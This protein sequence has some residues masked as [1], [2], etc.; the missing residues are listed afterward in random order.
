MIVRYKQTAKLNTLCPA[1]RCALQ[2]DGNTDWQLTYRQL[3]QRVER[4]AAGL[5]KIGVS[6]DDVVC[7]ASPNHVDFLTACYATILVSAT[8]QPVNPTYMTS[9]LQ[10]LSKNFTWV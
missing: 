5:Q 9:N 6:K 10:F 1:M 8:C 3:S 4:V 7:I 2:V